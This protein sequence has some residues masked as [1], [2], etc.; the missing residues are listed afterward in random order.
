[1]IVTND[2]VVGGFDTVTVVLRD[3]REFRGK[4]TRAEDS[5][6]ALVK[7]DA[8]DLPVLKLSDSARVRPGEFAIAIGAP[9][10]L[11]NTVTIGHISAVG[12]ATRIADWNLGPQGRFYPDLIQTDAAIN[13]G[14]SGGPLVNVNGDVIG[15]NTSIYSQSGGSNGL[16]FA[17]PANRVRLIADLLIRDGKLVRSQLGVFPEDIKEYRRKELGITG[18]ALVAEIAEGS[19]AEKA[20]LRKDDVILRIGDQMISGQKD[21]RD[22]ML[23]YRP[24]TVVDVEVLRGKERKVLKVTLVP[25]PKEPVRSETQP[26]SG[27]KIKEL[28]RQMEEFLKGGDPMLPDIKGVDPKPPVP[29]GPAQLGVSIAPDPSGKSD[30]ALIASVEPGSVADRIG[31]R[32]GDLVT[33]FDGK[34]IATADDL[35]AAV[36]KSKRGEEHVIRYV[37]KG[38]D[39]ATAIVKSLTF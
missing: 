17:I 29:G 6:I 8:K 16:A 27:S 24:Q 14:N 19:P 4:V 9:Y 21:V 39:S 25:A 36:R 23:R 10:G 28:R 26:D 34:R 32:E 13:P 11:D 33:E 3:G 22:A 30:G 12:R 18:G 35:I 1:M 15:V 5:D 20:G 31:M 2:H 37:R 38:R 7:I